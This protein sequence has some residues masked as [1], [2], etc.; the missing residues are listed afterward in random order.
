[1]SAQVV[2][3]KDI[4]RETSEADRHDPKA[5]SHDDR[6]STRTE[7]DA[8]L[9]ERAFKSV[10]VV[11]PSGSLGNDFTGNGT[12][13]NV[14]LQGAINAASARGGGTI[15]LKAG[16]YT[17]GAIVNL[18]SNVHLIG[19]GFAT[20]II[21]KNNY[22]LKISG[23][24]HV[25]I[26]NLALD[27]D[28]MT[29][30]NYYGIYAENS[31]FIRIDHCELLNMSGFGVFVT[32]NGTNV[33]RNIWI[34]DNYIQG[35]GTS[36]VIGGG[37]AVPTAVVKDVFV[38]RNIVIQNA[39]LG[40][41]HG[42]AI[43]FVAAGRVKFNGNI[44]EGSILFGTE[45]QPH[46]FASIQNNTVKAAAGSLRAAIGLV[47]DPLATLSGEGIIVSGNTVESGFIDL[48]SNPASPTFL[49][50]VVSGNV[51]KASG[52][53]TG[54]G[55]AGIR[56]VNFDGVVMSANS[57]YGS[58]G[59]GIWMTGCQNA[60][61]D[62]NVVRGST[63]IGIRE[64][65]ACDSNTYAMNMLLGNLG[66]DT[67]L[68]GSSNSI[69]SATPEGV[70]IGLEMPGGAN[71]LILKSPDGSRYRITVGNGGTLSAAAL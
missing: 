7:I 49:N 57:V 54:L 17:L 40:T 35:K 4:H 65:G 59:D 12:T 58:T 33:V 27:G 47:V 18:A 11:G 67:A 38:E 22:T 64:T 19:E 60:L 69:M 1:M 9:V 31:S 24:N 68:V 15:V 34:T 3:Y 14:A 48:F 36:D 71:G 26:S 41:G 53:N 20:K 29:A 25:S 42:D 5:H 44:T 50:T 23:K 37:P 66:G 52:I 63:G 13:D 55:E 56:V 8:K 16:T 30:G 39:T 46:A 43:N 21:Q 28:L 51:I 6:Y 62:G 70:G 10:I 61:V 32:A 45:K 2:Q